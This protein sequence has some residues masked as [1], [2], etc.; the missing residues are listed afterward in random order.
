MPKENMTRH[1]FFCKDEMWNSLEELA[2]EMSAESG[3]TINASDLVRKAL[4]DLL[5]KTGK[6][7]KKIMK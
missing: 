7:S 4:H 3:D 6:A 2:A 1:S 5:K